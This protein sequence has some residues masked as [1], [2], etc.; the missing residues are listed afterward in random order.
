MQIMEM[1]MKWSSLDI[2]LGSVRENWLRYGHFS[3]F[4]IFEILQKNLKIFK[5]YVHSEAS[6]FFEIIHVF[7]SE[8]RENVTSYI[9]KMVVHGPYVHIIVTLSEDKF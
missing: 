3:L 8:I 1:T 2:I 9:L 7:F 6:S 5:I 4:R